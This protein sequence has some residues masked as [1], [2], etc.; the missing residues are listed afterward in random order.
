[1]PRA[2]D[3]APAPAPCPVQH[4]E[5]WACKGP[6]GRHWAPHGVQG[7]TRARLTNSQAAVRGQHPQDGYV[8]LS[9]PAW[10]HSSRQGMG[11][12]RHDIA[13]TSAAPPLHG[14]MHQY[15]EQHAHTASAYRCIYIG[16]EIDAR[17]MHGLGLGLHKL[18][19]GSGSACMHA[20]MCAGTHVCAPPSCAGAHLLFAAH[21]DCSDQHV[22]VVRCGGPSTHACQ[23][24]P[25]TVPGCG[26]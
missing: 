21:G 15:A 5:G 12:M 10:L 26:H 9:L 17:W 7:P 19:G 18:P 3:H 2:V 22:I 16:N 14:C 4:T 11:V 25:H 13:S 1:M 23:T 6:R 8:R 20:C 24:G